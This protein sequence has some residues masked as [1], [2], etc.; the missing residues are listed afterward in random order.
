LVGGRGWQ[1]AA[2]LISHYHGA[3]GFG[4]L[5]GTRHA[6]FNEERRRSK[7]AYLPLL[8][9]Q[10]KE[11]EEQCRSKRNYSALFIYFYFCMGT[12]K[13]VTTMFI[14]LESTF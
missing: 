10:R 6:G 13:W 12:Q 9:V 3:W 14:G 4:L 7:T 11:K 8:H 2:P 5:Q 1:G